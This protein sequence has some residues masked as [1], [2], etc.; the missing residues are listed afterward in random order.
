TQIRA[1][2]VSLRLWIPNLNRRYAAANVDTCHPE[3]LR[4]TPRSGESE[5]ESK[6]PED[7]SSANAAARRS[8]KPEIVE[9]AAFHLV[10]HFPCR[11]FLSVSDYLSRRAKP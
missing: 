7:L 4:G 1:S 8:H 3:R 5:G 10:R 6:D 2:L 11:L 9:S